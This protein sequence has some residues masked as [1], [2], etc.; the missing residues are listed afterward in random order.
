MDQKENPSLTSTV[1]LRPDVLRGCSSMKGKAALAV[2]LFIAF[3]TVYQIAP[4]V[5]AA[6]SWS[7]PFKV[8]QTSGLNLYPAS[9]RMLNGTMW[10]AWSA[11]S[12]FGCSSSSI[13]VETGNGTSWSYP[14]NITA[15]GQNVAPALTQYQS[16][17]NGTDYIFLFWSSNVAGKFNI[18]YK[19][20]HSD[21][22]GDQIWSATSR[23]TTTTSFNDGFPSATTG[24]DGTIWLFWTRENSTAPCTS[25]S[26]QQIYFKTLKANIWSQD[27]PLTSGAYCNYGPSSAVGKDGVLRLA[28]AH[29]NMTYPQVFYQTY[30]GVWSSSSQI[31]TST[32]PDDSPALMQD[33][34]GTFWLFWQRENPTSLDYAIFGK[35]SVDDGQ[36]WSQESQITFPA[37]NVDN[38]MPAAVQSTIDDH[39]YLFFA[40]NPA[41]NTFY[42]YAAKS[43][44][45][46][47]PVHDVSVS[48]F[49][50]A[51]TGLPT[52]PKGQ[53]LL[54]YPGGLKMTG[55]SAN[56][57]I[58][59][60][61][62]DPGDYTETV[63]LTVTATNQTSIPVG[64]Q[65]FNLSPGGS[66][67]RV[68]GWNTTNAPPG[69]YSLSAV[70]L[71]SCHCETPGNQGDLSFG[72]TNQVHILPL[73]DIDQDGNVNLID[74]SVVF[75]DFGFTPSCQCSR[76][77]P[78][79]DVD[80][81]SLIGIIDAGVAGRNFGIVT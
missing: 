8:A 52:T 59:V 30:N 25:G 49:T 10:I 22:Y 53:A 33:R 15:Q 5:H 32:V 29:G 57:S 37:S 35:T 77:N 38:R 79:A 43:P 7:A 46:I 80:G 51:N 76:W 70:A 28:Y 19:T 1:A 68:F 74:V 60:A 3:S 64:T 81:D 12:I 47:S 24:R 4:P 16:P 69:R 18:Y 56:V 55:E 44:V 34:N 42:I 65:T 39:V 61:V 14:T 62:S 48:G 13:Y 27:T 73:G 71:P 23:V 36:T 54:Q 11:C 20:F 58:S 63:S 75:Y 72:L 2:L 21:I 66:T 41:N 17:T 40:A 9:L 26:A 67:T 45:S 6:S 78:Y 31:V 50:L